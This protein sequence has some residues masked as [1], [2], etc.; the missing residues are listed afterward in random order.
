MRVSIDD[1]PAEPNP[2]VGSLEDLVT[3]ISASLPPSRFVR[4]VVLDGKRVP[5]RRPGPNDGSALGGIEAVEIRTADRSSWITTE[6]QDSS[7]SL[8]RVRTSLART[9]ELFRDERLVDANRC[10][11]RCLEALEQFLDTL[12]LAHLI[13]P[14]LGAFRVEN[15]SMDALEEDLARLL[16]EMLKRQEKK[17]Y[18]S[19]AELVECAVLP[20]LSRWSAAL[21][22]VGMSAL[23]NA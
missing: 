16:G 4:E 7:R 13:L 5:R 20:A 6:L 12:F 19:L 2:G 8:E 21:R 14:Q 22:Q 17:D 9:A 10:L 3:A 15:S 23:S 11:L 1:R 18:E